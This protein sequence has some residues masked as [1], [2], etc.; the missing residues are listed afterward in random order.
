MAVFQY[1]AGFFSWL[2]CQSPS[3]RSSAEESS[4]MPP[5]SRQELWCAFSDNLK[6][7]IPIDCTVN[8]DTYHD[9]KKAIQNSEEIQSPKI[10][11]WSLY[12]PGRALTKDEVFTPEEGD[13]WLSPKSLI[14]ST[15]L[16]S[17]DSDIDIVIVMPRPPVYAPRVA[18][19]PKGEQKYITTE[20][21]KIG[22]VH[23]PLICQDSLL[24]TLY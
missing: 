19:A 9:L 12:R 17:G 23:F 14:Q 5:P 15:N 24:R 2:W 4:A 22:T 21:A 10:R 20:F 8:K 18:D 11:D 1:F 16:G 7:I 3:S 13:F 6:G